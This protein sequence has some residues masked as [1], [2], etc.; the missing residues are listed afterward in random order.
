MQNISG[1]IL[2]GG[3]SRRM[4]EDKA[5][6]PLSH[7]IV[8]GHIYKKMKEMFEQV[9]VNRPEKLPGINTIYI[10]DIYKDC[11]PLGGLHAV[12]KKADTAFTALAACDMPFIEPAVI[13]QLALTIDK[14]TEAV[15]PVFNG[16]NQPLSGIYHKSLASQAEQLLQ[17]DERKMQSLLDNVCVRYV[18]NFDSIDPSAVEWHFFNMNTKTDYEM[19]LSHFND[20]EK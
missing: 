19:A 13:R 5:L 2:A 16:R 3:H 8:A 1:A 11:G 10:E 6:L 9:T 18:R 15:V 20:S 14:D 12:L 17:N 4:G 7:D